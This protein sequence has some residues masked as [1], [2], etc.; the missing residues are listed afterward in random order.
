MSV[1]YTRVFDMK[2][3]VDGSDFGLQQTVKTI[4]ALKSGQ[5]GKVFVKFGEPISINNFMASQ[6]APNPQSVGDKML[7]S[8]QLST[9]ISR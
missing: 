1:G 6:N 3:I 5:L 9:D 7:N 4:N 8:S 2:N